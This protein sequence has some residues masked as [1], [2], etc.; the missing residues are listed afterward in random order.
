MNNFYNL[1]QVCFGLLTVAVTYCS[2]SQSDH[3]NYRYAENTTCRITS[4]RVKTWLIYS[5]YSGKYC[6]DLTDPKIEPKSP[7]VAI[8]LAARFTGRS[9]DQ[10][11]KCAVLMF[12]V[13]NSLDNTPGMS[14]LVANISFVAPLCLRE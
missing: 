6:P 11:V 7:F 5:R 1:C 13:D 8:T 9:G 3:Y 14:E 10:A 12:A 4:R 2:I